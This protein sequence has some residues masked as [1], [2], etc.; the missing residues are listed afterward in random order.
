ME[1]TPTLNRRSFLK[2]AVITSA[3]FSIVPRYV[4][5]GK[6]YIAPSDKIGL[7]FIGTGKQARGL[8]N[9]FIDEA[10]TRIVAGCDV[11]KQKLNLFKER[12]EKTMAEKRQNEKYQGLILYGQFEELLERTDIDAVV[13]A[14][15]DHWHAIQAIAAMKAGKDVFCEKPM[16]HTVEE[17]RAMVKATRKYK[18]VFQTGSMQRSNRNFRHACELVRNGYLGDIKQVKVNVGDPP[19]IC[20][21]PSMPTP[22]YLDWNR[23]LGPAQMRAFNPTLS[24]PVSEDI[25]PHWRDYKEFG[26]G[27]V[28]DWGAHM[29]DIAQWGLGMDNSGPVEFI[30]PK[31]R[32]A[33]RGMIYTYANG[34]EMVHEDFGR[35][36]GVSF[37]GSKGTL[38]ISRSYLDSTPEPI[39]KMELAA[40]DIRLYNSDNHYKDWLDCIQSR[41]MPICDV[42]IGHRTA[43]VCNITNIAYQLGRALKWNPQ[44]EK[45]E[46]DTEANEL[47]GKKYR[48]P[49][50]LRA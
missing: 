39:A 46:G 42:E 44:T 29:F 27:G 28:T 3:V 17:G 41:K 26:G 47:L 40:G 9:R 32:S 35:S 16:A 45:F 2:K 14:T 50:K 25:F 13:I 24:P 38:N 48:K 21:L 8:V 49:W 6:G 11:D 33:K 5:G 31:D 15:P 37:I 1:K 12:T 34:V 19:L 30:P 22:E 20:D 4:L 36:W 10:N 23:W 43:S 7:G 18:R